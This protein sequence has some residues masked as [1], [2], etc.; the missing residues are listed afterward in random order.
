MKLQKMA[1]MVRQAE[2]LV[3][4]KVKFVE[5]FPLAELFEENVSELLKEADILVVSQVSHAC[6]ANII[7]LPYVRTIEA[8]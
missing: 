8:G 6:P 2:E 5:G 4:Q 3:S 1:A 7:C